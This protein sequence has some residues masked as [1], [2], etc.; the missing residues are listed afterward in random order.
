MERIEEYLTFL[1]PTCAQNSL[2]IY[3]TYLAQFM[4]FC[5]E[6]HVVEPIRTADVAA[7][8]T[9]SLN[10]G[11]ST[12][13]HHSARK[14]LKRYFD[15]CVKRGY[16]KENPVNYDLLQKIIVVPADRQFFT[17]D[18]YR[19][20]LD[21][22]RVNPRPF[23]Y[24]AVMVGWNTGLRIS[25]VSMLAWDSIEAE[26]EVMRIKL[27]KVRRMNITVEIPID[28]DLYDYLMELKKAPKYPGNPY[29]FPDMFGYYQIQPWLVGQFRTI[30]NKAGLPDHSFHSLRHSFISRMINC[31]VDSQIV[32]A[33]TGLSLKQISTY[34]HISLGAKRDAMTKAR[35]AMKAA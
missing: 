7:W 28:P 6:E 25:D 19:K 2:R 33:I 15:W 35:L 20:V 22:C 14:E 1:S 32:S 3:R 11:Q 27:W 29:V 21:V 26:T 16:A 12:Y 9:K 10:N 8:T 34:A 18:N 5:R 13:G 30:C 17:V 24:G 23:W 31:G 4:R